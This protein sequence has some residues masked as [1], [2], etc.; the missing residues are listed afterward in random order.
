M[1]YIFNNKLHIIKKQ[2]LPFTIKKKDIRFGKEIGDF[3]KIGTPIA[4]QEFLTNLTFLALCAFINNL[5]LDASNGY[6][7]AQKIQ[8]FVMLIP[9]AIFQ[10]MASFVAQNVGA[11]KE[12]RAKKGM[13]Y[14]MAVG[15]SIGVVIGLLA[16]FKGDM[17]ASVFSKDEAAIARAFEFMRGCG[18]L[19]SVQLYGIF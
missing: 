10:C 19:R 13:L 16:F 5:G 11:G 18:H 4:L 7:I 14:G 9:S 2:T 12:D 1:N 17:L 6:G 3:L 15:C 8:S